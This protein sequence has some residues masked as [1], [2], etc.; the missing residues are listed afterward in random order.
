MRLLL[1]FQSCGNSLLRAG[2]AVLPL[3]LFAA[4]GASP[5]PQVAQVAQQPAEG[6][7]APA[8][9]PATVT[10]KEPGGD[11]P[12][13]HQAALERLLSAPWG[14]RRDKAD[15][16][17]VPMPDADNWKRVRYYGVEH[18]VG[19]RYGDEHHAMLIAFIQ[20]L[21][22]GTPM[23]SDTCVRQFE[24]WGLP[25]THAFDVKFSPFD[26]H[27][28]KWQSQILESRSVD[29][30]VNLGFEAAEFSGAWA[31]YPSYKDACLVLAV[32]VPW[33]DHPA[34]AQKLRD[35]FVTEGFPQLAVASDVRPVRK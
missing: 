14:L 13:P 1:A 29:G 17:S 23:K 33:R 32:A 5:Q 21:P 18:Y 15:Q 27:L 25:Q 4:C 28:G 10:V 6:K 3:A 31:A 11:A 19:F 26:S 9:T 12:D 30:R 7:A 24:A 35:R 2:L 16:V 20:E 8:P 34:L 22:A